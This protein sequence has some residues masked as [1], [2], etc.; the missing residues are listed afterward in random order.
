MNRIESLLRRRIGL[1]V[2]SVGKSVVERTL[3]LRMKTLG[4]KEIGDY[5]AHINS[6]PG[7]WEELLE[8]VVVTETWF[9]RD[10]SPFK[11]FV[12]LAERELQSRPDQRLRVLSLPCST[13]EEPYSLVMALRDAGVARQQYVVEGVDISARALEQA[14]SGFYRKNSFRGKALEFR[15]RHFIPK[16]AG[17]LL[18]EDVRQDVRFAQ[19]NLLEEGFAKNRDPYDFV[20]C[21]NLLIYFDRATQRRALQHLQQL[22]TPSGVLFVGP[23]EMPLVSTSGFTPIGLPMAFAGR[24]S[25]TQEMATTTR[26]PCSVSER[27]VA[28]SAENIE[29]NPHAQL[30]QARTLADA[31]HLAQA[32]ALCQAY[33]QARGPSA[34]AYYLLGL[35]RDAEGDA[36]ALDYYRKA[37]YLEPNHRETLL[38]MALFLERQGDRAGAKTFK[39]RAARAVQISD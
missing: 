23:A 6:T 4:L 16:D 36:S 17:F 27:R 3:R 8:A 13:G 15:D 33:L 21:R 34:Q 5:L 7:E 29:P 1:D 22:L 19:G 32:A 26:P 35:I 37:L 38:Q 18:N 31:G 39:R 11:A 28:A 14:R 25:V 10:Q 30:F 2:A 24:K 12:Q 9:F 20:F